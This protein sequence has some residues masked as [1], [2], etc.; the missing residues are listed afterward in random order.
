MRSENHVRQ[1]ALLSQ[2]LDRRAVMAAATFAFAV[3][4]VV[5]FSAAASGAESGRFKMG[6]TVVRVID[7]DTI[8]VHLASG[9]S[10]RVRLVGIDAPEL[11]PLECF[12]RQAK[13]RASRLAQGKHVQLLGD[14]TQATRDRYRRLLAYVILPDRRDLGR[15]LI[16]EGFGTVYVYRHP[17][18]RL[19]VYQA[20]QEPARRATRGLWGACNTPPLP[21]PPIPPPLPPPPPPPGGCHASYPAVCI[22]PPPPDLDCGD[23]P[24]RNF[25][26]RHDV[27]NPDPHGFDG[28]RDGVGCEA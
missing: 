15:H 21:P 20:A 23:I 24:H 25:A 9:K 28:N 17:F 11:S 1:Q 18:V 10:E 12:G 5:L 22:P 14:A 26:V 8:Q 7:G 19:P 16:S 4:L 13:A 6:G 27:P 2:A 3:A